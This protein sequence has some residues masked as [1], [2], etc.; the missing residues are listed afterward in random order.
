MMG[1]T[2]VTEKKKTNSQEKCVAWAALLDSL[3][4][5]KHF[6]RVQGWM[7]VSKR[8]LPHSASK[9]VARKVA[10]SLHPAVSPAAIAVKR[11]EIKQLQLK[12]T[13]ANLCTLTHSDAGSAAVAA[14]AAQSCLGATEGR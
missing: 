7:C 10:K 5:Q 2:H 14:A 3:G 1:R 8:P 11:L 13:H 4:D 6:R 12:H 9:E